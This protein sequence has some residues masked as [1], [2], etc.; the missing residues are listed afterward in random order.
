MVKN[1]P[2]RVFYSSQEA[3]FC[4]CNY[5]TRLLSQVQYL[6]HSHKTGK[7]Q[8]L[9]HRKVTQQGRIHRAFRL[10]RSL[11]PPRRRKCPSLWY[12]TGQKRQ[13]I[14]RLVLKKVFVIKLSGVVDFPWWEAV[15]DRCQIAV[16]DEWDRAER[17]FYYLCRARARP[18]PQGQEFLRDG[19]RWR[20]ATNFE[21][22]KNHDGQTSSQGSLRLQ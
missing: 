21:R 20:H 17:D 3:L 7:L 12:Y 14:H 1:V 8:G 15:S 18:G 19:D 13:A 5:Q 4:T 16:L 22:C 2:F 6:W 10:T 11:Y 9:M